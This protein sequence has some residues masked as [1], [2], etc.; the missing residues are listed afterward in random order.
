MPA[1]IGTNTYLKSYLDDLE[2]RVKTLENPQGPVLLW[3]VLKANLPDPAINR[4][5]FAFVTDTDIPVFSNGVHWLRTDT[6]API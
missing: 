2:A 6:G 5:R 3:P 4:N 1:P